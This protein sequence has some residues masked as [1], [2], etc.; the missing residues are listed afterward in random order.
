MEP[1]NVCPIK[2]VRLNLCIRKMRLRNFLYLR[3]IFHLVACEIAF[4]GVKITN[5]CL[6]QGKEDVR[7]NSTPYCKRGI[8]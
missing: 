3:K 4:A 5:F 2:V 7:G 1:I 6:E 8:T